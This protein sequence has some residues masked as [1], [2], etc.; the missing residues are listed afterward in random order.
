VNL[1]AWQVAC[2][3]SAVA[4]VALLVLVPAARKGWSRRVWIVGI[5]YC[6]TL[7]LFV[8]SNRMT[9]AANSIFLQS[10]AP[11]Y[12]LLVGPWLLREHIR[13][14][15][16]VLILALAAGMSLFFIGSEAPA[17]TA[18]QPALGNVLAAASGITWALT[19]AGLRW[20]GRSGESNSGAMATVVAGNILACMIALP[21]ALPVTSIGASDVAVLLYLGVIQ[22]GLAYVCLTRGLR[23]VPA[24]EASTVMLVEPALNPIWA[25]LIH[26]ERPGPL[27]LLGGAIILASTVISSWW[28]A[29]TAQ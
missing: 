3:R 21:M 7:L 1:A 12:L 15:D 5:A 17:A 18:P 20:L 27:A 24:F 4:A 26:S 16:F 13:R 10:T 6:G 23:D 11:L 22:I 9:T 14:G 25:W 29:R 28:H 8:L 19:V 2:F